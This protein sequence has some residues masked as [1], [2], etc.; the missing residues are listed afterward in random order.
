[1]NILVGEFDFG[2][3]CSGDFFSDSDVTEESFHQISVETER[4]AIDLVPH[5]GVIGVRVYF[6]PMQRL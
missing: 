6:I 3:S 4:A 5:H 2:L 1:M